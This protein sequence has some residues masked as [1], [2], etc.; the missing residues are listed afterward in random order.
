MNTTICT[1]GNG[2]KMRLLGIRVGI[3]STFFS[4]FARGYLDFAPKILCREHFKVHVFKEHKGLQSRNKKNKKFHNCTNHTWCIES[5]ILKTNPTFFRF[6][7]AC[8][9]KFFLKIWPD[10]QWFKNFKTAFMFKVIKRVLKNSQCFKEGH[11]KN[12]YKI[13]FDT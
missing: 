12:E 11:M 9:T 10:V 13:S 3:F 7:F 5:T 2:L 1:T 4:K 8:Q 6:C